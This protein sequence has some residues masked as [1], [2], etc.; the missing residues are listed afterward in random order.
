MLLLMVGGYL[1]HRMTS[2]ETMP[3][4]D[5]TELELAAGD[6][7][8]TGTCYSLGTVVIAHAAL[9]RDAV[10]SWIAPDEGNDG[11][12]TW[13]LE[14]IAQDRNGPVALVQD[15]TFEKVGEQVRLVDVAVSNGKNT[16]PRAHLDK[17]LTAPHDMRSTPV[18][19]CRNGG[20]GYKFPRR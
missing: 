7:L 1:V 17:L 6:P 2:D 11:K 19:R 13:R 20:S 16:D 8:H 12:W 9:N 18:D 10:R 5:F 3:P 15:F 14:Q 4:R